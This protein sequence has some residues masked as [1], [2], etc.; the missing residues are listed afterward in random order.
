MGFISA[1]VST[2]EQCLRGSN[3]IFDTLRTKDQSLNVCSYLLL[4]ATTK[5]FPLACRAIYH[6]FVKYWSTDV[7]LLTNA[8]V[9]EVTLVVVLNIMTHL[10]KCSHEQFQ[11]LLP[12]YFTFIV[13]STTI[14]IP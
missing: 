6:C 8:A 9:P 4:L 12:F 1:L 5:C 7:S 13:P 14:S 3:E 11:V 10:K 2:L